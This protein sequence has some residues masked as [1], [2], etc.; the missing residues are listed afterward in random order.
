MRN[1]ILLVLLLLSTNLFAQNSPKKVLNHDVYDGWN[2]IAKS[3]ISNNGKLVSYEVNPQ[4]GDG[5]LWVY[6]DSTKSN[7]QF[8]RGYNAK[9]SPQSNFIVFQVKPQFEMTRQAKL[10]KKK[11]DEMPKDS[12]K[13]FVF[14]NSRTYSFPNAKSY[15]IPEDEGNFIAI[16]TD[17]TKNKEANDSTK[18]ESNKKSSTKKNSTAGRL[19]I[20]NPIND[21]SLDIDSVN[22]YSISKNGQYI[23]YSQITGDSIKLSSLCIFDTKNHSTQEVFKSNG[24]IAQVNLD[25]KGNQLTF[26]F[27]SDTGK[28]KEYALYHWESKNRKVQLATDKSSNGMPKGWM[29]SQHFEPFF[30]ANGKRLFFGTKPIPDEEEKDTLLNDEKV[31]LDIWSW[32]DTLLQTQQKVRLKDA[33]KKSYLAVYHIKEK[34]MVQLANDSIERV[35]V[36]LKGDAPLALAACNKPYLY[37]M[38]WES[39]LKSDHYLL[40]INTGKYELILKGLPYQ[41]QLSPAGKYIAYYNPADSSWHTW[42]IKDGKTINQ[43]KG[44]P[45]NFYDEQNDLPQIPRPYGYAGWVEN[46]KYFLVYDKYDIWALDPTGKFKPTCI[47]NHSG[48]TLS[49]SYRIIQTNDNDYISYTNNELVEVFN[50]TTKQS[51]FGLVRLDQPMGVDQKLFTNHKYRFVSKAK[52]SNRLIWQRESF[53]EYRDLWISGMEFSNPAKISNANPQ[54]HDYKWGTVKL[55]KWIDF[56][57]DSVEGLLYLPEDFDST[58]KY[59][60]MVYFYETHTENLFNFYDPKPSRSVISPSM[61]V[62]NNY[63]VFMPNIKYQIG[64]PGPSAYDAVI[65]GTMSL[66]KEGF[67]DKDRIG[68]QGQSWGGYQVAYLVTRTNLFRAASAGAPVSN[69]TSAYGG[70]RWESG[71]ARMFQ[72]EHT[73]SRIGGTLWEKPLHFIENSPLFYS[74]RVYTPLLIR[75]DD[76][77]GAVPW[78]QGIELFLALRRLGKPVWLINYNNDDHNLTRYPNRVDW[79]IRMQQFFDYYLKDAPMPTWMKGIPQT[80]K[81]KYLGYELAE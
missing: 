56:N 46:D 69:M 55:Y 57:R 61:Y 68:V 45:A 73:Q 47:T 77:D 16:L 11:A 34:R 65:S 6:N 28:V 76:A 22:H 3:A 40:D 54:M 63:I 79:S 58:L 4:K 5:A 32:T 60:M 19:V 13:V 64:Y 50:H 41:P 18:K 23:A 70:I 29:V 67:V 52:N 39:P 72:Y 81:G 27:T 38:T 53:T 2:D 78:Y 17:I 75:H 43:T 20:L 24:E 36:L 31:E 37:S 51:G 33:D 26:V 49:N 59:P 62:S 12:I 25:D 71:L 44:L 80:K 42:S 30:S 74:P 7:R 8:S 14:T 10:A 21:F 66:I 48:R 15:R 35:K 9:F 1:K